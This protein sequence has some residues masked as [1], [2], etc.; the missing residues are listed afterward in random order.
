MR[1]SC[2]PG[3]FPG[4]FI[5]LIWESGNKVATGVYLVISAAFIA[6]VLIMFRVVMLEL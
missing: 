5:K 2:V 1:P 4:E 6:M 3:I